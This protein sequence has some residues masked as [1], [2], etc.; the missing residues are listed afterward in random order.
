MQ[1]PCQCLRGGVLG[2]QNSLAKGECVRSEVSSLLSEPSSC[3]D[4]G[5]MRRGEQC[6]RMGFTQN[7]LRASQGV[8][9]Q[10]TGFFIFV[11]TAER[12]GQHGG[13]E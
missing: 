12:V 2:S 10:E 13:R 6:D 5:Q 4:L 7:S 11:W 9:A 3:E 1:H 8:G